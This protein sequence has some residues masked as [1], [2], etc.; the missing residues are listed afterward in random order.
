M[1]QKVS[2]SR[3]R[4]FRNRI[5]ESRIPERV[6]FQKLAVWMFTELGTY[7]NTLYEY[8]VYVFLTRICRKTW[9]TGYTYLVEWW[10]DVSVRKET[11]LD[12]Y[13][14]RS[15]CQNRRLALQ[16]K[17]SVAGLLHTDVQSTVSQEVWV[18]SGGRGEAS[19][20][21]SHSVFGGQVAV[22][23][24]NPHNFDVAV[25][26]GTQAHSRKLRADISPALGKVHSPSAIVLSVWLSSPFRSLKILSQDKGQLDTSFLFR[27][28][29]QHLKNNG[30]LRYVVFTEYLL[31]H[32]T[33]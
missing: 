5:S 29:P 20:S 27:W 24:S 17:A 15:I 26:V 1:F 4:Y 8:N 11:Q 3:R 18:E 19:C 22:V 9:K 10:L 2:Y 32:D 13:C 7:Y 14:E 31:S 21:V 25:T 28:K 23:R 16:M 33:A 30:L 6:L 12:S